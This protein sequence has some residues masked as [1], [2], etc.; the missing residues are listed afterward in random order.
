MREAQAARSLLGPVWHTA[1]ATALRQ[2]FVNA[3]SALSLAAMISQPATCCSSCLAAIASCQITR[4]QRQ[5]SEVHEFQQALRKITVT[6]AGAGR[7]VKGR[8]ASNLKREAE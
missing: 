2:R 8:F 3:L 4:S 6:V 1:L 5:T 7:G